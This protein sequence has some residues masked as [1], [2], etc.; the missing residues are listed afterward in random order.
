[1]K[2]WRCAL[3]ALGVLLAGCGGADRALQVRQLAFLAYN[4]NPLTEQ[5]LAGVRDGLAA[6]GW[7]E[8]TEFTL[9]VDNAQGDMAALTALAAARADGNDELLFVSSTPALQAVMRQPPRAPVVFTN[10]ADPLLAG[11][12]ESFMRHKPNVTGICSMVDMTATLNLVQE[13]LPH[14]RAV[15]TL[16]TPAEI[17]TGVYRD[18][19]RE[20]ARQR[21]WI[22][23]D[24]PVSGPAE[25]ATAAQA[26]CARRPDAIIQI[27]D[28]L[29]SAGMAAIV[30]A[31]MQAQVPL[32]T[33][34]MTADSSGIVAAQGVDFRQ[35]GVEAAGMALRI[36]REGVPPAAIPIQTVSQST[37]RLNRALARCWGLPVGETAEYAVIAQ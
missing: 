11:V 36:L 26:M 6:A 17:N 1:M 15:A 10:T 24:V 37:L 31:A 2:R 28:N 25:L 23:L 30:Q 12:G 9:T 33:L 4:D 8:G 20:A 22:L 27:P 32:F 13:L 35:C 18:R 21:G 5:C 16:V 7:R 14:T 19:L 29:T 3:L 34:T